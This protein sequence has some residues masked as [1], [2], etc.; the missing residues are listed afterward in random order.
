MNFQPDSRFF[1]YAVSLSK[2]NALPVSPK[3]GSGE[4]A[5]RDFCAPRRV[6]IGRQQY[7]AGTLCQSQTGERRARQPCEFGSF[8]V[9]QHDLGGNSHL[10]LRS[11]YVMH[12]KSGIEIS[13]LKNAKRHQRG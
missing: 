7:D 6:T 12:W 9:G 1:L 11:A 8:F 10:N 5:L 3:V 13:S 4:T 2:A